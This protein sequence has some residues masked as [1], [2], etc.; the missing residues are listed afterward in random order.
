MKLFAWIILLQIE[1]I[2]FKLIKQMNSFEF[3]FIFIDIRNNELGKIYEL[4]SIY[5]LSQG[6]KS[7]TK[8]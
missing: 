8:N 2:I 3:F 7:I 5:S 4:T 6:F 1:N